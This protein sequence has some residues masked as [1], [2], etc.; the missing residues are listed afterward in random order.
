MV[1]NA[2]IASNS[3]HLPKGNG[4]VRRRLVRNVPRGGGLDHWGY[5]GARAAQAASEG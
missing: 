3:D 1:M 5:C 2:D 4:P